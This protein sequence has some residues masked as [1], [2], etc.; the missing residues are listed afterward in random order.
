MVALAVNT[1]LRSGTG[2][3]VLVEKTLSSHLFGNRKY[4]QIKGEKEEPELR[5]RDVKT[6]KLA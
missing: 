5:N 4:K 1:T 2:P 6:L 3:P